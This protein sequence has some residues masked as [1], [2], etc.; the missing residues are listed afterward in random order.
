MV[1][2]HL[3]EQIKTRVIKG[4]QKTSHRIFTLS[5][6]NLAGYVPVD[7]GKLKASGSLQILP[8]GAIIMYTA[9][10]A[11]DVEFGI[12]YDRPIVGSQVVL[13]KPSRR[14]KEKDSPRPHVAHYINKR[15]I[16][17]KPHQGEAIFRVITHEKAR[18]GQYFLT[19]AMK[20]SF[21]FLVMDI[22]EELK[23]L[24]TIKIMQ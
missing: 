1:S 14:P 7:S 20:D 18:P 8:N 9:S 5:Q 16:R 6:N 10:Y 15:L 2:P 4:L 22:A 21:K 12:A 19:R 24:G 3:M 11:A 17:I 23:D 13:V